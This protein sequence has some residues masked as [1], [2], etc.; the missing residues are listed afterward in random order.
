MKNILSKSF[1]FRLDHERAEIRLDP[2]IKS[3]E[4]LYDRALRTITKRVLD[5]VDP[6]EVDPV[7]FSR[8]LWGDAEHEDTARELIDICLNQQ[9]NVEGR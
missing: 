2:E 7:A 5:N 6:E 9:N 8:L 1:S 3:A 4:A